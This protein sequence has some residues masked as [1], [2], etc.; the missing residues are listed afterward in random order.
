V[1]IPVEI[2]CWFVKFQRLGGFFGGVLLVCRHQR[3]CNPRLI[4][5]NNPEFSTLINVRKLSVPNKMPV[6][7]RHL[8][9]FLGTLLLELGECALARLAVSLLC[10][11]NSNYLIQHTSS[12]N[13]I[14]IVVEL[15][16]GSPRGKEL[17]SHNRY[18]VAQSLPTLLRFPRKA[19]LVLLRTR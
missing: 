4:R 10:S 12:P 16:L 17:N 15:V 7:D 13:F 1:E 18:D 6:V 11:L 3:R 8:L 19:C 2:S 14:A 5:V 9:N